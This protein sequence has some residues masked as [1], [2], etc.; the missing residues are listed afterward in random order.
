MG[1]LF[2]N[3]GGNPFTAEKRELPMFFEFPKQQKFTVNL[4]IPEGYA[5][6]SM[7]KSATISTGENVGLFAFN[8]QNTGNKIQI[9]VVSEMK[10]VLVSAAF[11]DAIKEFYKA[12][13]DKLNEKIVLKKI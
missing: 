10:S 4:E 7:P 6:E 1:L 5:V 13:Y 12:M 3:F 2:L 8:I 9:S 11:Y